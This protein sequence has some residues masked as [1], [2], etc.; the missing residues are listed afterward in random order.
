VAE[1]HR[2]ERIEAIAV[3]VESCRETERML[4]IE[5]EA[6]QSQP[7]RDFGR[8]PY[9]PQP[10]QSG[11]AKVMARSGSMRVRTG[12]AARASSDMALRLMPPRTAGLPADARRRAGAC[13][14]LE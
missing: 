11:Q 3:L 6:A 8:R 5:P 13:A 10:A 1:A 12:S 7:G 4:E 14:C 2:T 9:R